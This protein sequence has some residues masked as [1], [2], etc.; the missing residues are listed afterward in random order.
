ML[1]HVALVLLFFI[2]AEK[3]QVDQ[4]G[5]DWIYVCHA[6]FFHG[7]SYV[8][9][10]FEIIKDFF[11]HGAIQVVFDENINFRVVKGPWSKMIFLILSRS[12]VFTTI[13]AYSRSA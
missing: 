8:F 13:S 2:D 5:H 1:F 10:A 12:P 9:V 4:V 6:I 3:F 7:V 11:E